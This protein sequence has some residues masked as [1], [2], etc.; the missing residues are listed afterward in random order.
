M[1]VPHFENSEPLTTRFVDGFFMKTH[2]V[3]CGE[4]KE[5]LTDLYQHGEI[6]RYGEFHPDVD[7]PDF[8]NG[9]PVHAPYDYKG[10]R[11]DF[12]DGEARANDD[13]FSDEQ[14]IHFLVYEDADHYV[15]WL[16]EKA[17]AAG[18]SWVYS[19][20]TSDQWEKAARGV[21]GRFFTWG[22]EFLWDLSVNSRSRSTG[23][24][25]APGRFDTD[26]SPYGILDLVGNVREFCS[27]FDPVTERHL[28]RGGDESSYEPDNFRLAARRGAIVRERHW[29]FGIRLVRTR[30]PIARD[31]SQ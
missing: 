7:G 27:D 28:V 12:P 16:N 11:F 29:D 13:F 30:R 21:D 2:E 20:P 31:P 25:M 8:L 10:P 22:N 14:A 26:R 9:A 3:T 5:F 19:L 18:E 24:P 17:R 23:V 15:Q 1:T 6:C 4:Y